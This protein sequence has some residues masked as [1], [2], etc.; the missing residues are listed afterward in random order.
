MDNA[1]YCTALHLIEVHYT[2]L[3]CPTGESG[4][5]SAHLTV[6]W[7]DDLGKE[8]V[9]DLRLNRELIPESYMERYQ[10]QVIQRH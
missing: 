7:L 4:G 1:L 3:H 2:A 10:H 8:A 5:H 9:M 6:A